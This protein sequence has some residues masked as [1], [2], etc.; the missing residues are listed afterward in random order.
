MAS[1]IWE[2][3]GTERVE[4]T[5][6]FFSASINMGGFRAE[7]NTE[8]FQ[9]VHILNKSILQEPL[10]LIMEAMWGHCKALSFLNA[11]LETLSVCVVGTYAYQTL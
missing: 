3:E 6:T 11:K 2:V 8:D 9:S 7:V 1:W 10:W 4:G 5:S